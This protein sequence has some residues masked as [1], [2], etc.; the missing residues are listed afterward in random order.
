VPALKPLAGLAL[1]GCTVASADPTSGVDGALFRSSY[2][3]GGIFSLEGARLMPK[4]D[5]S[6]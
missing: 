6:F 1:V 2:D 5:V 4:H 3:T